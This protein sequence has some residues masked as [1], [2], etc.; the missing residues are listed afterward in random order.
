[1]RLRITTILPGVV[2][3]VFSSACN[4]AGP[5]PAEAAAPIAAAS[6][7]PGRCMTPVADR[8]SDTGCYL[9]AT[10]SLGLLPTHPLYWH[11]YSYPTPG[12]AEAAKQ[13]NA[14]VVEAF[15]KVWLYTIAAAEWRPSSGERVA[16][17][18]PLPVTAGERYVARYMEAR[19]PPGMT[20]PA[21]RH[22]GPEA[23]YV[24]SGSQCLET[25]TRVL[26]ANAGESAVIEEGSS[27]VLSGTGSEVRRSLLLVLYAESRPWMS[28]ASDW[29]PR[30]RC[31]K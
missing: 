20:T 6:S 15:D 13:R 24:L 9:S 14:V 21:H 18:G 28:G 23:W 8:A 30:G 17:V 31:P 27:M 7:V 25:P 26:V 5:P 22:G 16:L 1:M 4:S 29:T 3:I 2:S 19:F 12:E 10:V 11:V